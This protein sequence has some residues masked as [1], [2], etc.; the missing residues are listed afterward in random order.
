[1]IIMNQ[2]ALKTHYKI[3][4]AILFYF[5]KLRRSNLSSDQFWE[6]EELSVGEK[7]VL[8]LHNNEKS[9]IFL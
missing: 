2:G 3:I 9:V 1:M 4:H 6:A 5:I 7:R 8:I